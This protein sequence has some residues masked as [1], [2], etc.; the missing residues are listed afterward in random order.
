MPVRLPVRFRG[1]AL[2]SVCLLGRGGLSP[3]ETLTVMILERSTSHQWD[4][5]VPSKSSGFIFVTL[6]AA[7]KNPAAEAVASVIS[8]W[9]ERTLF[10]RTLELEERHWL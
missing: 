1:A 2:L 6:L 5:V 7:Q 8:Y 10:V 9:K 4:G 3:G